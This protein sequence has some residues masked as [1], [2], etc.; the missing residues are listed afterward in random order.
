M[1]PLPTA[2]MRWT[3]S[4]LLAL[5]AGTLLL[6]LVT[7]PLAVVLPLGLLGALSWFLEQQRAARLKPLVDARVDEDIGSFARAFDRRG[8][9]PVDP[10]AIR[11]V[12]NALIP[13]TASRAGSVA[14]RPTDEMVA[15]LYVD[16][17]DLDDLIEPL[18]QQCERVPS[19]WSANP[20]YP[21]MRTVADLVF[22]ISAQPLH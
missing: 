20:Y 18:V 11:A 4:L 21:R 15:D 13:F 1:G 5:L 9:D 17:D 10:W 16:P 22:F 6:A 2:R 14:L 3:G 12:W 8:M 19:N 7:H